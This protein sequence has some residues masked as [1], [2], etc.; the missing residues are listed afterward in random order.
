MPRPILVTDISDRG[1]RLFTDIDIPPKFTLSVSGEGV[2][3]RR[4][5][6]VVW[7]LGGEVGVEFVD[8]R[9]Q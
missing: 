4:D 9:S 7:K 8:A 1:A 6:R 2:N 5:C 3:E